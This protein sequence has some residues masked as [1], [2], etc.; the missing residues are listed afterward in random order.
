MSGKCTVHTLLNSQN[1]S[2]DLFSKLPHARLFRLFLLLFNCFPGIEFLKNRDHHNAADNHD[3]TENLTG[4]KVPGRQEEVGRIVRRTELEGKPNP[5]IRFPKVLDEKT[6]NTVTYKID[7]EYEAV[8]LLP[9][10]EY[11][12]DNQPEKDSVPAQREKW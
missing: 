12:P 7:T 10:S 4:R 5:D 6:D 1:R 11:K 2:T 9:L 8:K 3:K